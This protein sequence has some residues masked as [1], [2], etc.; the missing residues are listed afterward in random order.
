MAAKNLVVGGVVIILLLSACT[1]ERVPP[2]AVRPHPTRSPADRTITRPKRARVV[3]QARGDAATRLRQAEVDLK[4]IKLW[5]KLADH[6]YEVKVTVRPGR[7][8]IP[9]DRHLADAY[10][11][12]VA[13]PGGYGSL[14]DIAFYPAA[15]S[16]DLARWRRYH[17]Q[18]RLGRP[19][20]TLR[21]Y[22]GAILA[23]ELGHCLGNGKGEPVAEKWERIALH[24]LRGGTRS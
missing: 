5:G 21:Q 11:S 15:I 1:A 7:S 8:D 24:K 20:A 17:S 10:P 2:V 16:A 14:C 23:H 12:A 6:L 9:N 22:W 3:F 13:A 4:R 19:P 18:G